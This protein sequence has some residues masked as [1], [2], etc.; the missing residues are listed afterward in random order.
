MKDEAVC[1][2]WARE[3]LR[4]PRTNRPIKRD[5]PTYRELAAECA[6]FAQRLA[7]GALQPVKAAP[8]AAPKKAAPV[9]RPTTS[10]VGFVTAL[11]GA[12]RT[13]AARVGE[14]VRLA[15]FERQRERLCGQHALNNLFQN[16]GGRAPA[17]FV[18]GRAGKGQ[19]DL[20]RFA[21]DRCRRLGSELQLDAG[22]DALECFN[23]G[24]YDIYL[25]EAAVN[26]QRGFAAQTLPFANDPH[27][28]AHA[29]L[30][31]AMGARGTVGLLVNYGGWHWTAVVDRG[32]GWVEIDS[33]RSTPPRL[34][35]AAQMVARL[36]AQ[37]YVAAFLV[38]HA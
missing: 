5:G 4:N 10:P 23:D 36:E 17:L 27:R 34:L 18:S 33:V 1:A 28:R 26:A 14:R 35:T 9:K 2:Q 15:F 37:G 29:A 30:R 22:D 31:A 8:K 32:D 11:P 25:L 21:Q 24:N 6:R 3:P 20:R 12:A 13:H 38:R 16:Y 19:F 7:D